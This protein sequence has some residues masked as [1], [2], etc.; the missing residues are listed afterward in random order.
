MNCCGESNTTPAELSQT[1]L[2]RG[3]PSCDGPS[4][5]VTLRTMLLMLKPELFDHVGEGQYRFC[6]SPDCQVVYFSRERSFKTGDL[7]V[8]VG[9]K[10]KDGP[11]PLC[12]CFG[13]SEQSAR[14]EIAAKGNSTIPQRITALIKRRMCACEERNPSGGCCLGE[15]AKAVKRLMKEAT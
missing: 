4:R 11:I 15:V 8:R 6:V 1:G 10:E 14:E 13:Y 12:Y 9:L 5:L 3:C 7:R 2:Q